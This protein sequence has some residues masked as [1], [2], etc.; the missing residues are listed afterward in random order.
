MLFKRQRGNTKKATTEIQPMKHAHRLFQRKKQKPSKKTL[1]RRTMPIPLAERS[2]PTRSRLKN[3]AEKT[4]SKTR[5]L[6]RKNMMLR[7][8]QTTQ[9]RMQQK[10]NKR[11]QCKK[12]NITCRKKQKENKK[13][14][15]LD[16]TYLL[17]SKQARQ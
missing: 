4:T 14:T 11:V 3:K 8:T 12:K 10:L 9:M 5:R 16:R 17:A 13:G 6:T 7:K 1:H 15:T 2:V